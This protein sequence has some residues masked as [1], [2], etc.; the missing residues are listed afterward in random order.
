VTIKHHLDEATIVAYAA[1]TLGPAFTVVAASHVALCPDCRNAVRAAEGLGGGLLEAT[2]TA[3][4]SEACRARTF[5]G[6]STASLHRFPA[7]PAEP[8]GDL[9]RAL[10]RVLGTDSLETVKWKKKVPGVSVAEIPLPGA[11]GPGLMLMSIAPGMAMPE[12]GHR[13]EELTMVLRG[14]YSDKLGRFGRGDVADLDEDVEHRPVVDSDET[15]ICLIAA[16]A[17]ARFKSFFAKLLQ[18]YLGI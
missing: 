4:V 8:D 16:E 3:D 10:Q 9:P 11:A 14:S 13:G 2:P 15:C 17:P 18:P 6:L 12:H 1:G 5:A 7:K